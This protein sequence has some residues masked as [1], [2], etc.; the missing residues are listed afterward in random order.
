LASSAADLTPNLTSQPPALPTVPLNSTADDSLVNF[1][2]NG[3]TMSRTQVFLASLTFVSQASGIQMLS[4]TGVA[5][6][7]NSTAVTLPTL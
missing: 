7:E 2:S 5:N 6:F 1:V 3:V 4:P